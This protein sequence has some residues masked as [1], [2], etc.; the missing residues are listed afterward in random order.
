[1]DGK[2]GTYVGKGEQ[3]KKMLGTGKRTKWGLVIPKRRSTIIRN[4]GRT[5][6]EKAKKNK[7]KEDLEEFYIKGKSNKPRSPTSSKHL[8][9]VAKSIGVDIGKDEIE[10]ENN[11]EACLEFEWQR[12]KEVDQG[13]SKLECSGEQNDSVGDLASSSNNGCVLDD[14]KEVDKR[15]SGKMPIRGKHPRKASRQ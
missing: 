5:S 2:G 10:I 8:I 12:K 13:A 7:R 1:V 11:L 4:D 6:L 14:S 15:G 3:R 9:N